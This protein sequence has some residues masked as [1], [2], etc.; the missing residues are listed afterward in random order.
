MSEKFIILQRELL[1]GSSSFV[2]GK[3]LSLVFYYLLFVIILVGI[4][5]LLSYFLSPQFRFSTEKIS[6]YECGFEPFGDARM[7]FDIHFYIIGILFLL[8]DLE[9][10]FLFPWLFSFTEYTDLM[11]QNL[12]IVFIFI[13]LLGFGFVYEWLNNALVWVPVRVRADN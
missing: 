6:S 10:V 11:G 1:S 13:G 7:A 4:I 5:L 9:I 3:D 2:F 12:M 8:F